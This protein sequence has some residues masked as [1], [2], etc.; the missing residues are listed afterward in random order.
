[1]DIDKLKEKIIRR[2]EETDDLGMLLDIQDIINNQSAA[3][4]PAV[5]YG[6]ESDE[7][8]V[9]YTVDGKPMTRKEY[10]A[11]IE[12]IINSNEKTIPHSEVKARMDK[13]VQDRLN[14]IL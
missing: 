11:D 10:V 3:A 4:E 12:G 1:M 2:I 14:G 6:I 8:I 9:A 7:D 5:T 13:W